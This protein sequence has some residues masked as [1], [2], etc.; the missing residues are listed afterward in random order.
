MI[1]FQGVYKQF[2]TQFVLED[3][4][5]RIHPG[6]RVGV[7]G[8]NGAGKS[9]VA[10]L[11]V[12]DLTPDKGDVI[13]PERLKLG[14]LRQQIRPDQIDSSLLEYVENALPR[15]G[16]MEH[17]I[18]EIER[19]LPDLAPEASQRE[20][21]RLGELQS[22][23]EH[24]GGYELRHR[25]EAALSGLGFAVSKFQEPFRALSGG[26][27]M[28]A[29]LVRAL[30]GKPDILILDEPTNFL[31]VPAVEW[32]QGFLRDFAGTLLLIS[33][34]RFLLD[35]LTDTTLE[36]AGTKV[37]RYPGNYDYYIRE[38]RARYDH[39]AAA[40]E[41]QDR[42]REQ[43][44][45][46]V[47]RF[48]AK[49]TKAASVQSRVRQIEKMEEIFLPQEIIHP[50]RI[51]LPP[52][53][54][55]GLET[56]RLEQVGVSYDGTRWVLQNVDLR[57]ERGE[58]VAVIGF[59]GMGKTTLLRV[60]AGQL[61]PTAGRRV[62]G[63]QV[64]PGYFAQ[65]FTEVLDPNRTVFATARQAAPDVPEK[66]LRAIL[67]SFRFSG[68]ATE[69][70]VTVLSGG[71]KSRLALLRLLLRPANLLILDEPTTHLDIASREVLEEA[72]REYP[73]TVILV[74]HD[75]AFVRKVAKTVLTLAGGAFKR[76]Y[77]DYDYYKSKF[78]AELAADAAA[79]E[80][81]APPVTASDEKRGR[82]RIE[83]RQRQ[84][85]YRQR[86]PL[87]ERL[88]AAETRVEQLEAEQAD[89]VGKL[90]GGGTDVDF[91]AVSRRLGEI[92]QE[93]AEATTE[94]EAATIALDEVLA[95]AKDA[96]AEQPDSR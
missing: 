59:N 65:E 79:R 21:R 48:R 37:T 34:D 13:I 56:M 6:E 31:D 15:L 68:D 72:L 75:I 40:K 26:W 18:H 92:Q 44:E 69:K 91:G 2:G 33:H 42:K 27:Q 45:R 95:A 12:G 96:E 36:V 5:F 63:H 83:A 66:E 35:S 84:E 87:E 73:G 80:P 49:A 52:P 86:K 51:R 10:S 30:I 25:A 67:G 57:L 61:A 39:L 17:E 90:S 22:E 62:M 54:H 74:S 43:L 77:G 11:L 4:S 19:R 46:F 76:Y 20:L 28:R 8:P 14:Y 32:L 9:T 24:G 3:A 16:A 89:L 1:D 93:V 7:V 23:F 78:A 64:I 81:G 58:K 55:C 47:E 71:E 53:P 41:N 38:R 94:W 50:P 60:L 82:K 85:L 29:E 70:P 88:Q